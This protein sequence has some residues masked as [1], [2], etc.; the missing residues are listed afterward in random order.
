MICLKLANLFFVSGLLLAGC[1]TDPLVVSTPQLAMAIAVEQC[2][3]EFHLGQPTQA[4]SS[5]DDWTVSWLSSAG[6]ANYTATID[7]GLGVTTACGPAA[8]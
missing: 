1:E 2:G 5:G 4:Q 7:G 8:S 6:H 3:N